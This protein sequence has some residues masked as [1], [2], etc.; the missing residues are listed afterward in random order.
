M[1]LNFLTE[2]QFE[3][4]FKPEDMVRPNI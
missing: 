3:E 1:K 2:K 4:M